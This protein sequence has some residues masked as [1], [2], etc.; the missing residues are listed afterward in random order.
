MPVLDGK[1]ILFSFLSVPEVRLGIALGSGGN[2][3]PGME[4]PVV[5][6]WLVCSADAK[7]I[8]FFYFTNKESGSTVIVMLALLCILK[9][10]GGYTPF[11]PI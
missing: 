4:L 2:Q 3:L 10:Q 8:H 1:A 5:S 7:F 6:S 9:L 11:F